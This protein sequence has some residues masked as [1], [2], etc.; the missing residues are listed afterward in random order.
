MYDLSGQKLFNYNFSFSSPAVVNDDHSILVYDIKG[1]MLT[2][3]NSFSKIKDFKYSG[4]VLSAYVNDNF[5][6]VITQDESFASLLRLYAYDYHERDYIETFTL[7][8]SNFLTSSAVTHN[9]KFV[10]ASSTSSNEGSYYSNV[11]IY[12]ASTSSTTPKH[13]TEIINEMP[14]KTGFA[15]DNASSYVITDSAVHFFNDDLEASSIYRFNQSKIES[16]YEDDD[17]II[18]AERNN[19]SGNSVML[20]ALNKYGDSLF[21]INISD[22]IFDISIGKNAIFALGKKGVYKISQDGD[23]K[24]GVSG[25]YELATK[26]VHIICDTDDNCYILNDTYVRKVDF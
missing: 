24:Y 18:L 22:E 5:F 26:Y 21:S 16:F 13:S 19:L 2:V 8:S 6:T 20:V 14:I 1:N 15:P 4:N 23:E 11:S 12:D 25:M 9:G 17:I 3:F 7:K 10:I